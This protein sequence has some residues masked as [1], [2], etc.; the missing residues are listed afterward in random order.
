MRT[1][2]ALLLLAALCLGLTNGTVTLTT[3]GT[4]VRVAATS[5]KCNSYLIQAVKA[6]AGIVYFGGAGVTSSNGTALNAGDSISWFPAGSASVYDLST[7]WLVGDTNGD[8]ATY[9]CQ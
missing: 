7:I 5:T 9:A 1:L 6:N 3:A 4:P 2:A 8:K